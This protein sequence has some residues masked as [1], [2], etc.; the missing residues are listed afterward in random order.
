MLYL[1][2]P[3]N[4]QDFIPPVLFKIKRSMISKFGVGKF[5]EDGI[6]QGYEAADLVKVIG[7]SISYISIAGKKSVNVAPLPS[8]ELTETVP[9]CAP[10]TA[11]TIASPNPLPSRPLRTREG[12]AR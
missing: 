2:V 7:K 11:S 5:I 12:S 9:P 8:S 4:I 1:T 6:A 10:I 3:L